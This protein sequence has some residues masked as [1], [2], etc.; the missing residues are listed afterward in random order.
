MFYIIQIITIFAV[1]ILIM[2]YRNFRITR[3]FGMIGTAYLFG[4][5]ISL[6]L[7]GL[8]KLGISIEINKDIGEIGSHVAISVAIPLL[9][10]SANLEET[11]KLSKTVLLSFGSLVVSV[12]IAS[13]LTFYLYG[14]TIPNGAELCAMA[15]G[16][17]TGGTPN[18]NAIGNIFRLDGS[19]IGVANLSDMIIG[20]A[21]YIFL[22]LLCKPLLLKFLKK[23]Q[24]VNYMKAESMITNSDELNFREFRRS[25]SLVLAVLIAFL[26][27]IGG[28]LL[29]VLFW[30]IMGQKKGTLTDYLIPTMMLAVTVMG[31]AASF[32]KKIRETKGTNIVGQYLILVFSF[33]LASSFDFTKIQDSF[34]KIILLYGIITVGSFVIHVLFAKLLS[35]D[36]D[37]TMVTAT[38]GIYGPAFI[39]ALTKQIDND[40]LTIPGLICGSLGY[41]IGTFLGFG[42]GMIF[43]I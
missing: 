18:L 4:I 20:G 39:P 12:I 33:A 41:A 11:R 7:F 24:S 21:F 40:G 13:S 3:I 34:G 6:I 35:I 26:M 1:P 25:R 17:Y 28:A 27:A 23:S 42:I 14:K 30:F 22:L 32:H 9:L 31:I 15:I 37:C 36:V 43:L 10:F 5:I 8:R 16:L 19:V 2:K 38:A 29:G